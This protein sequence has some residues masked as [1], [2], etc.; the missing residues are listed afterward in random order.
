MMAENVRTVLE[1]RLYA[2]IGCNS[3]ILAKL[4]ETSILFE[5]LTESVYIDKPEAIFV[6][7]FSRM[8]GLLTERKL[9]VWYE[10]TGTGSCSTAQDDVGPS[11]SHLHGETRDQNRQK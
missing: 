10:M 1:C 8:R 5:L 2:F 4:E 9:A 11:T 7:C 3:K 6:Q